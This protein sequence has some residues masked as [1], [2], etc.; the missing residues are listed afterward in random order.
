VSDEVAMSL[1][2]NR[3]SDRFQIMVAVLFMS[4]FAAVFLIIVVPKD[5]IMNLVCSYVGVDDRF[6]SICPDRP[7]PTPSVSGQLVTSR[8][9]S[10]CVDAE[11]LKISIVFDAPLSG[12]AHIQVF[13][14]GP[15]FFPSV[16]GMTD[17]YE[18][19]RTITTAVDHL[20]LV[21]PVESMPVGEPIF[22]NIV[23]SEDEDISSHI[24]YLLNVYDCSTTNT[25]L[26]NQPPAHITGK[27]AIYS[28]T[29]LPNRQLMI[30]FEFE[31]PVLGQYQVLV[32]NLPYQLASVVSQPAILFFSGE[33]PPEGSV[34]IWLVSAINEVTLFEETYTPPV[35]GDT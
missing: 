11:G 21:I 19:N 26:S 10:A 34:V 30:A 9:N 8:I 24:A 6:S 16:R 28:A 14:T 3:K 32:A 1:D 23:I 29:C 5:N 7:S 4:L 13:S 27:P 25:S 12:E 20:E 33:Q 17:T 2:K 15:D 18:I 31:E 35:C 22:G